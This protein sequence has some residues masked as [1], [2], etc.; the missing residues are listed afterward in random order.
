MTEA[1]QCDRC[2]N[3]STDI[4]EM[5]SFASDSFVA[6]IVY[7]DNKSKPFTLCPTCLEEVADLIFRWWSGLSPR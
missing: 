2:K 3:F 5:W 6:D 1:Y 7:K 4:S